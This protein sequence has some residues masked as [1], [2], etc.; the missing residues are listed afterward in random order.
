MSKV[1]TDPGMVR[2]TDIE[3]MMLA[4]DILDV[5]MFVVDADLR[6][7]V[8]NQ[9][10]EVASGHSA[11]ELIG[12]SIADVFPAIAGTARDNSF[13]RAVAGETVVLA[14]RFH[15]YLLPMP[16]PPEVTCYEWMQQSAR[17]VPIR[18]GDIV[19]GAMAFIQDVSER[20]EQ[21]RE[22]SAAKEAAEQASHAKSDF[23]AAMS[24]E[25]RTPLTAVIGYAGLLTQEIGGSLNALQKQHAERIAASAWHLIGIIDEVLTFSRAEAGREELLLEDVEICDAVRT[26]LTLVEPQAMAK[27]L[28]IRVTCENETLTFPTDR[29]R[30][31]QI[32]INLLGNAVKFT[33]EGGVDIVL[34][35][36]GTDLV[37]S[38]S[39]T[40]PGV[41]ADHRDRVFE[42]FTQV[43]QTATRTKGGTGLG[44]PV[45]RKLAELMGG[46]LTLEAGTTTGSTFVLRLPQPAA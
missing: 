32:M 38:V 19:T 9:W 10:M 26:A 6:I 16:C 25:L 45:S 12:K 2:D 37:V 23:L 11:E 36:D 46:S 18:S 29:L 42:A 24:H 35:R 31:Q 20:V 15:Q 43:D 44:L 5:G 17:I 14:H 28:K 34:R 41:P 8:W 22:L 1:Q 7:T 33:D 3:G 13:R 21:E 27:N 40:G 4:A 39:D 30:I